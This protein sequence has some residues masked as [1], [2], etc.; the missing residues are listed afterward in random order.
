MSSKTIPKACAL[1]TNASWTECETCK[2]K[3]KI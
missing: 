3:Y 1:S 2:Q